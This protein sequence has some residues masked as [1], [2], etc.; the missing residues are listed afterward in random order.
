VL[1]RSATTSSLLVAA[2]L[3]LSGAR[4]E[5]GDAT[6]AVEQLRRDEAELLA[7]PERLRLRHHSEKLIRRWKAAAATATGDSRLAALEGEVRA[8]KTLAHWSGLDADRDAAR[9]AEAELDAA[10]RSGR[11]RERPAAAKAT[12]AP[13]A[14]PAPTAKH[15]AIAAER[16]VWISQVAIEVEGSRVVARLD[17]NRALE[18]ERHLIP[19]RGT[20]PARLYFDL[21]PAIASREALAVQLV[22]HAAVRRLRVGQFDADTVRLVLDLEPGHGDPALVR[23]VGGAAPRLEVGPETEPS[24]DEVVHADLDDAAALLEKMGQAVREAVPDDEDLDA[25]R[26]I[27]D[28]LRREHARAEAEEALEAE[29]SAPVAPEATPGGR[30]ATAERRPARAA[31]LRLGALRRVVIDA[32]HGGKDTGARGPKGVE[33]KDVN[34]AIAKRLG[35]A[36]QAKL[37]VEVVYTRS[38]DRFVSLERRVEIANRADADLFISVHA[39]AHRSKKIHGIETYHLNTSSSRYAAKL[40]RRENVA[41]RSAEPVDGD[42]PSEG[43]DEGGAA[44][45][46]VDRLLASLASR[47]PAE[48]SRRLAAHVQGS[49]VQEV[50]RGWPVR[51]LGVKRALFYVLLG[52]RMPAVL[53]ETGFVTNPAEAKRL[54]DARYQQRLADAIVEGV[55]RYARDREPIARR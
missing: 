28:E 38:S 16:P 17:A 6:A 27:V 42:E 25:L 3:T 53:V 8:R 40:A 48:A 4:V 21:T 37:G 22:E 26:A 39:N 47:R 1:R 35:R 44:S 51:D 34:L 54:A 10:R 15:E 45:G 13:R 32:G 5:A 36:L 31:K 7:H 20:T 11:K 23:F 14:A 29:A 43:D 41:R 49:V 55:R 52:V 12:P 9:R 19:A 30:G 18:A 33:E 2:L 46:G 24:E 50:R